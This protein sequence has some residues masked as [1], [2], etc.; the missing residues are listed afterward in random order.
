MTV[1]L[2]GLP[3][4]A[5]TLDRTPYAALNS[6]IHARVQLQPIIEAD[7]FSKLIDFAMQQTGCQQRLVS[8]SG[9]ELLRQSSRGLPRHAG[10]IIITA[11]RMAVPKG[12]NHLPDDLLQ[13]AI[14]SLR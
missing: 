12:L 2:A 6:R 8:D 14:E 5:H 1:W 4:L 7:R 11:M 10:R 13:Q 9:M 3:I